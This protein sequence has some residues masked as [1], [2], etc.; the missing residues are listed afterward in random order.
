MRQQ[1]AGA[2][3]AAYRQHDTISA[4]EGSQLVDV[5]QALMLSSGKPLLAARDD[6]LVQDLMPGFLQTLNA[7]VRCLLVDAVT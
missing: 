3:A 6:L 7:A 4:F 5:V 2:V 1:A